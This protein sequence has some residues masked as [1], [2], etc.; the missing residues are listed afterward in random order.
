MTENEE[1]VVEGGSVA[2]KTGEKKKKGEDLT[3]E[4]SVLW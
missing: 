1:S 4:K 2:V 3:S